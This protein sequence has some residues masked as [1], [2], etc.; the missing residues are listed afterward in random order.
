MLLLILR[1]EFLTISR[2]ET[3]RTNALPCTW[4]RCVPSFTSQRFDKMVDVKDAN[5]F[6]RNSATLKNERRHTYQYVDQPAAGAGT[7]GKGTCVLLHGFPDLWLAGAPPSAA[8]NNEE[9]H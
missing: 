2:D 9:Q 8:Y 7:A 3:E 1:V 5:T 4:M 6:A